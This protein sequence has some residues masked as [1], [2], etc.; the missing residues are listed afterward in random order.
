MTIAVLTLPKMN[1]EMATLPQVATLL[2]FLMVELSMSATT[3]ME[4][5]EIFKMLLM[6]GFLPMDLLQ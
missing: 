2:L 5:P 1:R 6:M 4:T 3:P